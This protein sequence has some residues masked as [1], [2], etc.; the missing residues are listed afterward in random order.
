MNVAERRSVVGVER[1]VGHAEGEGVVVALQTDRPL[2]AVRED[3]CSTVGARN[4]HADAVV[5]GVD[6]DERRPLGP[7]VN[8]SKL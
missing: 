7:V 8:S 3:A 1:G 6:A 5:I 2:L 4:D